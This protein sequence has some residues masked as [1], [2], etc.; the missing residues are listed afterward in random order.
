MNAATATVETDPDFMNE[1]QLRDRAISANDANATL[2]S[3]LDKI[4]EKD[5]V[6]A[7]HLHNMGLTATGCEIAYRAVFSATLNAEAAWEAARRHQLLW[8]REIQRQH[9]ERYAGMRSDVYHYTVDHRAKLRSD[10]DR[11]LAI[12]RIA[13]MPNPFAAGDD[14]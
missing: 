1:Q 12:A 6:L 13:A 3:A 2:Y 9:Q 5:R 4:S 7:S 14:A 10:G 8:M 11:A